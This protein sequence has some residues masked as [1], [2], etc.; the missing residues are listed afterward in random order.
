MSRTV[1]RRAGFTLVELLVV[2][3]IIAVLISIL[4]PAL[5][6]AR[7]SAATIKCAA[8]LRSVGQGLLAY[9]AE[10][11]QFLP[12]SYGYRGTTINPTTGVQTP[13]GAAYGYIHWTSLLYGSTQPDAFMCPAVAN[14]G[15]PATDPLP[16]AFD[17]GQS[18]DTVDTGS[19]ATVSPDN[20]VTAITAIDGT[21]KSVTYI[22]DSMAARCAYTLNEGLCGRNK[23]TLNFQSPP[24]TRTYHN[25]NLAQVDSQSQTILA[26]EF[27]DEWGIVSGAARGNGSVAVCKSHRPTNPWVAYSGSTPTNGTDNNTAA[28]S[29]V[30]FSIIPT[31]VSMGRAN[32]LQT[33]QNTSGTSFNIIADYQAGNYLT[34]AS[35]TSQTRLDWVGR[36]HG[37]GEKPADKKTNFLY[38]DGHVETKTIAE[39]IPANAQTNSPWEWGS[40][41]FSISP[42]NLA[43]GQY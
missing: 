37:Y 42:N 12:F 25:V 5:Q 1:S 8:N 3:G 39:T 35:S 28:G 17:A 33:W 10:N 7:D 31:T 32:L 14:G 38:A 43:P 27:V 16:G 23:F 2:I 19:G 24:S 6:R 29:G 9:A 41:F 26:T 15:L 13:T 34:G 20:R 11:K 22:P 18:C 40:Q 36:N 30:D 21:G 4:L